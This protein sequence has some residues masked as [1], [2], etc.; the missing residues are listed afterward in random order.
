MALVLSVGIINI[1]LSYAGVHFV[2]R[3]ALGRNVL[4]IPNA[5]SSHE[6]PTPRGGGLAVV[7]IVL[8]SFGVI[9]SIHKMLSPIPLVGYIAAA[10]L[11]SVVSWLDDL[12]S[13]SERVR[14][15]VH[16]VGAL[17]ILLSTGSAHIIALPFLDAFHIGWAAVPVSF[18][19]I[20]GLINAYN[21]MDGIDG[22]AGSQAVVAGLGWAVLGALSGY[23]ELTALGAI[24]AASSLGFLLHNWPPAR[25]FMGDVGAAFLGC[26]FAVLTIWGGKKDP[27]FV[28]IG[29]LFVWPFI[30]DATFTFVRR[31]FRRENV[32]AAH[33]SHLYQRLVIQGYS[34][35]VVTS[36]YILLSVWGAI[37]G[38]IWILAPVWGGV[39]VWAVPIV[40]FLLWLFT[41]RSERTG[42]EATG[43]KG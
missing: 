32:F 11:I 34:H 26:T 39:M 9:A 19:W 25:I 36:I 28:L 22:L 43:G 37:S 1:I 16:A 24:V 41:V 2:R 33:R 8:L 18:L 14:F 15:L 10:G 42:R 27:R 21:F 17:L 3:W 29:I 20:V 4:D 13:L 5:R 12:S 35:R 7:V 6:I 31:L 40:A 23:Q 38:I 30:F